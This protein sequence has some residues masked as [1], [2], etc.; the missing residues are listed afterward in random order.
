[1]G[2]TL[3]EE[4]KLLAAVDCLKPLSKEELE[5]FAKRQPDVY[6]EPGD[7]LSTPWEEDERLLILKKGRVRIYRMWQGREQTLAHIEHGT[8]LAAHR[9]HGSY[10]EAMEPVI[11]LAL[12][13]EAAL[14]LIERHPEVAWRLIEGL[15][16]RMRR[17]DERLA[18]IALKKT[19]VRLASAILQ[20]V[21][22]E[23]IATADGYSIPTWYTHDELGIMIGARRVAIT[24]ALGKLKREE[25]VEVRG[26]RLYVTDLE[27]LKQLADA[28]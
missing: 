21:E 3:A 10:V 9:L 14:R 27:A 28:G 11:V 7:I 17:C 15:T 19:P 5:E 4:V 22:D 20:L 1:M 13:K 8:V 16:K 26:H 6:F 25:G 18:D 2:I 23:G 12:A 24:R